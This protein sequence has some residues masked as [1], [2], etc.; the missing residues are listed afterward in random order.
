MPELNR[1]TN[2]KPDQTPSWLISSFA[3]LSILAAT[4]VVIVGLL[5]VTSWAECALLLITG[6]VLSCGVLFTVVTMQRL[7]DR[8]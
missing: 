5:Q 2:D 8:E 3:M 4:V 1:T 7:A 6:I